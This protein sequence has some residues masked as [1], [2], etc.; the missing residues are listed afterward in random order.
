MKVA[1][2]IKFFEKSSKIGNN[3]NLQDSSSINNQKTISKTRHT[4]ILF[5]KMAK[6]YYQK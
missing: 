1:D 4:I 3:S 6:N 5:N 2:K